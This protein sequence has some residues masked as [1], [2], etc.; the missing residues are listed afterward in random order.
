MKH[1]YKFRSRETSDELERVERIFSNGELYFAGRKQF[2]DPFDCLPSVSTEF[3]E[4][5]L[6]EYTERIAAEQRPDVS[7]PIRSQLN[8]ETARDFFSGRRRDEIIK[9]LRRQIELVA[10]QP[11][12][13]SLTRQVDH[14]LMWSHYADSHK[15]IC[16]RFMA[17]D[18]TPYFGQAQ[19]VAYQD[20]R[21]ALNL[22]RDPPEVILTKAL[23][24]KA[25]FWSYEDEYRILDPF[26]GPGLQEF[27]RELLDGVFLGASIETEVRS[28][29]LLSVQQSLPHVEI[30]QASFHPEKF[31][32]TFD[33]IE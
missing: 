17:T 6:F 4:T 7:A 10:N 28:R 24:T 11:G 3:T 18:T 32:L 30:H 19:K 22:V 26:K 1:L 20:E 5:E 9:N 14:V 8:R 13:L 2:N 29:V 15:G 27:P 31:A 16:L 33:R 25:K 21:P 12:I 23:L